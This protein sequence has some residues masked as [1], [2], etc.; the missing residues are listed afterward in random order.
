MH[1]TARSMKTMAAEQDSSARTGQHA[2]PG[3]FAETC[4]AFAEHLAA[5]RN[6]SEHTVRAYRTDLETM[7]AALAQ[8]G[9]RTLAAI[10]LPQLRAWLMRPEVAALAP[11]TLARKIAAARTFFD[12]A[13]RSGR[14]ETDP[15]RRLQAPR[16]RGRLPTALKAEQ[17][18]E[19]LR[20]AHEAAAAPDAEP[21]LIRD[22]AVAE[23]LYATGVRVSELAGLDCADVDFS[24]RMLTVLGKGDKERRVPFGAPAAQALTRWIDGPREQLAGRK[25]RPPQDADALFIGIRGGRMGPRAIRE[26]VHRLAAAVPGAPD[27]APHAL[28]HSAATHL[29]EGGAD[30]RTVQE[31]LGHASLSSTQI[32]T[33]VSTRRLQESYR[34]A[35]PRA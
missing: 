16:H 6:R 3:E 35:H 27:I 9:T 17:A 34:Q 18:A 14:I 13:R 30:L 29:L 15:S 19:L 28:R 26:V 4:E 31:L 8:D 12:W 24:R 2:L 22:A 10:G 20:L 32:Y 11:A 33:H 25:T 7:L 21:E 23:L 1:G 5:E